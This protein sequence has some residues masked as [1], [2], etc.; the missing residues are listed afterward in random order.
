MV[1]R[2]GNTYLTYVRLGHSSMSLAMYLAPVSVIWLLYKLWRKNNIVNTG[3]YFQVLEQM[4]LNRL[5]LPNLVLPT[6]YL[7]SN[8][9]DSKPFEEGARL[10]FV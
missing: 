6:E 5:I 2:E 3:L 1:R 8:I 4:K 7:G 10:S 9:L